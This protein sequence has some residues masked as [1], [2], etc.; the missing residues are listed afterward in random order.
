MIVTEVQTKEAIRRA[1][2]GF[3]VGSLAENALALFSTLGY[4]SEKRLD[5]S[6]NTAGSFV[7]QFDEAHRLNPRNALLS[8]WKSVDLLFQLTGDEITA[9]MQG[10]LPFE[11]N[12]RVD[13]SIIE[14]YVFFAVGLQGEQYTRTQLAGITREINKLF[15]MPVMVLFRHGQALTLSI[16]NRRLHKRDESRD[17][18]AEDPRHA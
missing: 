7:E 9:E 12:K 17:V 1:L 8:E 16:I 10:C 18:L 5:L 14:S 3:E 11:F 2:R 15:P 13:N 4:C 6:P